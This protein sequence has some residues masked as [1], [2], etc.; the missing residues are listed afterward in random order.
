M[1]LALL[2]CG[3]ADAK[4]YGAAILAAGA[5]RARPLLARMAG[6]GLPPTTS[7]YNAALAVLPWAEAQ[8]EHK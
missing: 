3:R 2:A 1:A 4:L 8:E 5:P 6:A 7:V